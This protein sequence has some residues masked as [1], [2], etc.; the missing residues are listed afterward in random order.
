MCS[1]FTVISEFSEWNLSAD[2]QVS[3]CPSELHNYLFSATYGKFVPSISARFVYSY[4]GQTGSTFYCWTKL[5]LFLTLV[6]THSY[7]WIENENGNNQVGKNVT[8][9]LDNIPRRIVVGKTPRDQR[10]FEMRSLIIFSISIFLLS[11]GSMQFNSTTFTPFEI[12]NN[13]C[14]LKIVHFDCRRCIPGL[15]RM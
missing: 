4:N 15:L 8:T 2:V 6:K 11:V 9:A 14:M 5:N 13:C 7:L 3:S 1:G 10:I 12:D